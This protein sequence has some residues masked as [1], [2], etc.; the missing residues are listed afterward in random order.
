[1]DGRR[2]GVW[3]GPGG[4]KRPVPFVWVMEDSCLHEVGGGGGGGGGG[5]TTS[6][7][8]RVCAREEVVVPT[9]VCTRE[10]AEEV[11]VVVVGATSR[12]TRVCAREEVVVPTPVCMREEAEEVVV[13][14]VGA[15][16]RPTRVR[17][18][19]VV[20]V[21]IRV[22]TREEVVVMVVVPRHA[23]LAFARGRWWY[24]VVGCARSF[25]RDG[26]GR[27][28]SRRPL[29]SSPPALSLPTG[30]PSSRSQTLLL[31]LVPF[32]VEGAA[33]LR[34]SQLVFEQ[35]RR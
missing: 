6:R 11:V 23:R 14:V 22:C 30:R 21:L 13:V 32:I 12:P 9:P 16:S 20:V 3:M 35:G 2:M 17:A 7:P 15:T 5:G 18:R 33:V 19:E 27:P 1:V 26:G 28:V 10:E 34:Q 8:T 4:S 25:R 24:L 29:L 31:L